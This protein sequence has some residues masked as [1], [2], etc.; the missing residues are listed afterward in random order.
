M[1]IVRILQILERRLGEFYFDATK[2]LREFSTL[3][4]IEIPV[5]K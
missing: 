5:R 3:Y 1:G 2:I 4:R